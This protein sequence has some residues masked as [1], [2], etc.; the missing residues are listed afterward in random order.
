M[1]II[2]EAGAKI[3]ATGKEAWNAE[4]V[5]K[6]KEPQKSEYDFM[7]EGQVVFTYF[8]LAQEAELTQA[9]LEHKVTAIAYETVQLPNNSITTSSADE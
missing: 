3:V 2:C 6:V 1:K 7:R 5:M 8:H 4:M 9:L